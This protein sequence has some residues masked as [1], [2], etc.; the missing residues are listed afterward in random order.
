MNFEIPLQKIDEERR[1]VIG[2]AAA[3]MLDKS[4]ECMDYASAKDAFQKWSDEFHVSTKGVSRGNLRVMH[5]K[6]VAGKIVDLTFD[7]VTKSVN[8]IAHVA[9]D[10]AWNLCKSG[11]FSGFSIGG[12][13]SRRWEQ[14][15]LKKYTPIIREISLV[16]SPCIPSARFAELI[17]ADGIVEQIELHGIVH[18]FADAWAARPIAIE[19]FAKRWVSR[20]RTFA[21][22]RKP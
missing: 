8:V 20:P 4:G 22:M 1:L 21:E 19:T 16:D 7:D 3:E 18:T 10:N 9:S 12:G 2:Q 15:G 14:D 17:K 11:C 5:T 13:Y 6:E